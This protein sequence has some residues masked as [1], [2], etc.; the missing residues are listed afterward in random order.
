MMWTAPSP[1]CP[2]CEI[3]HGVWLE[4]V[5]TER[6]IGSFVCTICD[7]FWTAPLVPLDAEPLTLVPMKS[8]P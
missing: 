3:G 5:Y 7:Y 8:P 2:H 1:L 6:G 4:P